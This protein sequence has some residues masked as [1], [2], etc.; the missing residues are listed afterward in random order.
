MVLFFFFRF[1]PLS[2]TRLSVSSPYKYCVIYSVFGAE[3]SLIRSGVVVDVMRQ[4]AKGI[5]ISRSQGNPQANVQITPKPTGQ[6]HRR[7][8]S[9]CCL[10]ERRRRAG[11][12]FPFLTTIRKLEKND[13]SRNQKIE[14]TATVIRR[15]FAGF[16]VRDI[17]RTRDAG[18]RYDSEHMTSLN[19]WQK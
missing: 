12:D 14:T 17:S 9:V 5:N 13:E 8:L 6:W 10:R 16:L 15:A 1:L 4:F 3:F 19:D 18:R 7:L 2:S 11:E